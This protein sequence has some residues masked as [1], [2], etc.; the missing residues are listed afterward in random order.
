MVVWEVNPYPHFHIPRRKLS[1]LAPA[2]HRT[3][4]AVV[5][6]YLEKA[7]LNVPDRLAAILHESPAVSRSRVDNGV[8]DRAAA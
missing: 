1:Y 2:V 4:A 5:H 3:L 8:D 7:G 6:L